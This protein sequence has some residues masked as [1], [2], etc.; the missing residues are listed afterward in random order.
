MDHVC[1]VLTPDGGG[2][3]HPGPGAP[4]GRTVCTEGRVSYHAASAGGADPFRHGPDHQHQAGPGGED[5]R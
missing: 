4:S 1:C 3:L 5:Q 2:C